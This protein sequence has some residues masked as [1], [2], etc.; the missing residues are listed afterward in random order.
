VTRGKDSVA[1]CCSIG[2]GGGYGGVFAIAIAATAK[3]ALP[4]EC[5]RDAVV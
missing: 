3:T 1:I 2:P 5:L 4:F